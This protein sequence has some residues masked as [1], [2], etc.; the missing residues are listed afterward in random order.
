MDVDQDEGSKD[1]SD[2]HSDDLDKIKKQD[3]DQI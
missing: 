2:D 1:S 3:A